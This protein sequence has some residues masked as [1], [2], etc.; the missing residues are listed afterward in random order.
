[1]DGGHCVFRANNPHSLYFARFFVTLTLSKLLAL[2]NKKEKKHFFLFIFH[3][4]FV[5]LQPTIDKK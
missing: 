1:M 4:F 2:G 5:T 3:S